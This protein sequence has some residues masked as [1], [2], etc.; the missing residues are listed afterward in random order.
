VL[1]LLLVL[2]VLVAVGVLFLDIQLDMSVLVALAE[3]IM[4]Q[5]V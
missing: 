4:V 3:E 5:L 1:Q 2:E